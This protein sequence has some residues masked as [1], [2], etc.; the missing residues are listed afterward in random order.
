M[1]VEELQNLFRNILQL[2]GVEVVERV[3][4]VLV[5]LQNAHIAGA[6]VGVNADVVIGDKAVDIACLVL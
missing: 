3:I 2:L 5:A 1:S 6:P 4:P